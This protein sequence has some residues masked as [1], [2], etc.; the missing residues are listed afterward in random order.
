MIYNLTDRL[1][2]S[3]SSNR[4]KIGLPRHSNDDSHVFKGFS[5]EESDEEKNNLS[6]AKREVL[7]IRE[8]TNFMFLVR[9]FAVYF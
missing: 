6:F 4:G 8:Q 2:E 5:Y 3:F 9:Q 7:F 1:F